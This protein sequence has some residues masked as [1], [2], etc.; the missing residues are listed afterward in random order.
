MTVGL[1]RTS[2]AS[3]KAK[4]QRSARFGT[5]SVPRPA[6]SADWKPVASRLPPNPIDAMAPRSGSRKPRWAQKADSGSIS[7]V[8]ARRVRYSASR[9]RCSGVRSDPSACMTPSSS[10][11]TTAR[12]D[13]VRSMVTPGVRPSPEAVWHPAHASSKS[14]ASASYSGGAPSWAHEGVDATANAT[15]GTPKVPSVRRCLMWASP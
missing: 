10:E 4:A 13:S 9:T 8:Y 5:S 7:V 15:A 1:V 3:G 6:A 12:G 11:A 14:A 2:T